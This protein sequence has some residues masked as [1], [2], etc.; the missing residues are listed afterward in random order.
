MTGPRPTDSTTPRTVELDPARR[1][2][3]RRRRLDASIARVPSMRGDV[4]AALG[5][6]AEIGQSAP[7]P[8]SGG[9]L[10]LWELLASTAATDVGVARV[11]EP[12]LDALSILAQAPDVVDLSRIGA[13]GTSTWGVFAAEGPDTRLEAHESE[14]GWRLT[15]VK[16]WC[17]LAATLSHALVTAWT[18]AGRR[19]FAVD[20]RSPGVVP[21]D[22]PWVARGFP[23]IVSAPVR[24]SG[25]VAVPVGGAGWYLD[26][27]GFAWGGIGV[28]ACWWGGAV[29]LARDLFA[30]TRRREP[31][32]LALAHL[33]ALD[34]ALAGARTLLVE[35]SR[36]VDGA[37][38]EDVPP[39]VLARRVRG[40]VARAVEE[41]VER[42][43]HALG[44]GPMTADETYARRLADLQLYV[45]QHHAERDDAALGRDLVARG[46]AP[47]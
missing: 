2:D 23:E 27:T 4:V 9:T 31:D 34:V 35:A 12:H 19:L 42:C 30:S 10:E 44:P 6:A 40:S 5:W 24:F 18:E 17:S 26:R 22:G 46:S 28:A 29:G 15:G 45:R 1:D 36:T 47:W 13:D 16:P 37:R 8:G 7:H 14:D 21:D 3:G 20:L 41:V 25:A 43:S 39:G 11:L 32:Q 33:G 38:G